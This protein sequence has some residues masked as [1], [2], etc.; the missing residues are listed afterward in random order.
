ML[1]NLLIGLDGSVDGRSALELGLR[2]ARR[3]GARLTG[4]AVVDEPGILTSGSIL[5]RAGRSWPE[6]SAKTEFE[7]AHHT[8]QQLLD[9]FGRRC[10]ETGVECKALEDVG[11]PFL[12][13]L[14]EAQSSDAVLLGRHTH[15][16]YGFAP[17]P[18]QTLGKVIQDSPRPVVAV[19]PWP[20]GG[21]AIV[22]AYDGSPQAARA[23]YAF[24]A[25]GLGDEAPIHVVSV[26]AG[27]DDVAQ[28]ADRAVAY[29]RLH[30]LDAAAHPVDATLPVADAV[31][32]TV[33]HFD[34]GLLVMG[35]YGEPVL[36]EFFLGSTTRSV[37]KESTVPVFCFH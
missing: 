14:I 28:R 26:G 16:D 34:A 31:L 32:G 23:L 17:E 19:P 1:K 9:E 27:L 36:K 24:Q 22:V 33:R 15:F 18:D 29:L 37:L 20:G 5:Y 8:A 25:S 12:Q 10:S 13:I 6:S 21:R 2:W 35:A 4:V 7:T 3:F 30:G 11:T